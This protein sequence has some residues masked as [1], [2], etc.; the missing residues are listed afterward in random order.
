[1]SEVVQ[2]VGDEER[3]S[4]FEMRSRLEGPC[5]DWADPCLSKLTQAL[6][7]ETMMIETTGFRDIL[8]RGGVNFIIPL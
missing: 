8:K 5:H 3:I 7:L 2:K 6:T 4:N 1:M